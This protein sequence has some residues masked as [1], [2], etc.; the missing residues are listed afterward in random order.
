MRYQSFVSNSYCVRGRPH[1]ST[2]SIEGDTTRTVEK[3]QLVVVSN[4]KE[5][6]QWLLMNIQYQPEVWEILFRVSEKDLP[7]QLRR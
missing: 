7:K 3:F 2:E 4:V 5:T 1:S 6:I